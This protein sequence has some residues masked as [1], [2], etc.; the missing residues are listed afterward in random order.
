M[1]YKAIIKE[2]DV[3]LHVNKFENQDEMKNFLGKILSKFTKE[4]I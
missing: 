2:Y 4:V 1:L 3:Q